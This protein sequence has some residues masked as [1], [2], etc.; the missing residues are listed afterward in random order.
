M[1]NIQQV[2]SPRAEDVR[3]NVEVYY[4]EPQ[5]RWL[6]Y[7]S[8]KLSPAS[9]VSH[10]RN[11]ARKELPEV[12]QLPPFDASGA[13]RQLLLGLFDDVAATEP[14]GQASSKFVDGLSRYH[15]I[16]SRRTSRAVSKSQ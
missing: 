2:A 12:V 3:G 13:I 14:Q 6:I 16:N 10:A 9:F 5:L 7:R 15:W 11:V 4:R 1:N 8:D